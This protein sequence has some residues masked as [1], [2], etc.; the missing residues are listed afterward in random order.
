MEVKVVS[1]YLGS[2]SQKPLRNMTPFSVDNPF[3][4]DSVV[5]L[6]T[7]ASRVNALRR[8]NSS[9]FDIDFEIVITDFNKNEL[10]IENML[11]MN[12]NDTVLIFIKNVGEKP[13]YV[14]MINIA[15]NN[16]IEVVSESSSAFIP[17]GVKKHLKGMVLSDLGI[18]HYKFIAST[19]F[20]DLKPFG[21]LGSDLSKGTRGSSDNF[22][23]DFIN[24]NVAGT[25]GSTIEDVE[26]TIKAIEFDVVGE[27]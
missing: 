9:S 7:E 19:S 2:D 23:A 13:F 6:I 14:S 3:L 12:E 27:K 4:V 16:K 1:I 11:K 5:Q 17:V 24:D 21:N 15:A 26:I 25:R 20:I 10:S 8:I 22:F 18:D